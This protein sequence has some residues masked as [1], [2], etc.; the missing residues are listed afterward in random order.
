MKKNTTPGKK[1][2]LWSCW[3]LLLC[4]G[5]PIAG[6][7]QQPKL[8]IRGNLQTETGNAVPNATVLI[9]NKDSSFSRQ[10]KADEEGVFAVYGLKPGDYSINISSVGY[11]SARYRNIHYDGNKVL[12][13]TFNLTSTSNQLSEVVVVGYGTDSKRNLTSS[14]TSVTAEAFNKG[15]YSDPLQ[16][17]QGKVAGLT[18][19]RSGDPNV[20]A[21]IL[22][23]GP[24]TLRDGANA[25][26]VVI[27]GVPDADI[28]AVAPGDIATI[29]VLKDAAATAI[30]GN[31]GANGIL[32]ITTR[33]GKKG[34]P[35]IA[36]DGYVSIDKVSNRIEVMN[37]AQIQDFLAKNNQALSAADDGG[38]DT[39]WQKVIQ[40]N[41]AQSQSHN[42]SVSGGSNNTMYAASGNYFK[43]EGIMIGSKVERYTGRLV[44]E[45]Q[46]LNNNLKLGFNVINSVNDAT[47]SPAQGSAMSQA[48]KYLPTVTPYRADGTYFENRD[49]NGYYNPLALMNNYSGKEQSKNLIANV[50]ALVKLP[51]GFSYSLSASYKSSQSDSK[52]FRTGYYALIGQGNAG[53]EASRS[54][55]SNRSSIL[56]TYLN[57]DKTFGEHTIKALVGYSYQKDVSGDGFAASNANFPSDD[58]SYYWLG[59]GNTPASYAIDW[60]SNRYREKLLI[61]D[62]GRLNYSYADKYLLQASIRHDGS[63]VFGANQRWGIFP[64]VSAGWRIIEERFM[65]KQHL[66]DDLK[67]RVGYGITGNSNGID[68]L[69]PLQIYGSRGTEYFFYEGSWI[70]PIGVTQNANPDLKWE[71]TATLNAA[72]D[73][74]LLKRRI[75]GTLEVYSK[76]TSDLIWD[77]PVSTTRYPVNKI[78]ANAGKMRN[79][80]IELTL[81]VEAVHGKDFTWSSSLNLS[82]NYNKIVSLTNDIYILDSINTAGAGG[83][84]QSGGTIQL[85]KPGLPIGQFFLFK[86]AGK[87]DD[88]RTQFYDK[89]GKVQTDLT[90]LR[91]SVDY[92][93]LGNAQPKMQIGWSN[94]FSYKNFDLSIFLRSTLGNKIYNQTRA[95]LWRP[96]TVTWYNIPVS[97]KDE[98]VTDVYS[99]FSSDRFIESGSYVRLDNATLGY[100]FKNPLKSIQSARIYVTGNNL[101]VITGYS[102]I[103]PEVNLSGL[104]PGIDNSSYYPKFRS[105]MFGL[106]VTL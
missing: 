74:S 43:Q 37:S 101:F 19:T 20:S 44:I 32:M 93:Q 52:S 59:W 41:K 34:Q 7:A 29:D 36:Y 106:N 8:S 55:Y 31:R 72:I 71:K 33:K 66:F 21:S 53:G 88:G 65:R 35:R 45:Q 97:A 54:S 80:G 9:T 75:S 63:S 56:E 89:S 28:D 46:A 42:I 90:S 51:A 69:T 95:E 103:D 49:H 13:L 48:L 82:H 40:R 11:A 39:D 15:V 25:P 18:I 12:T 86:Y 10:V 24:S 87:S 102:G 58:L 83:A 60:G 3:C 30:Y 6:M 5:L 104:T 73:F 23:R 16:I 98:S 78:T 77:Y 96:S 68:A 4:A 67:L 99:N 105:F 84:G 62:Y 47:S 26:L 64:S 38:A 91:N 22:L 2:L 27:D 92:Y 14:I 57:Y 79:T 50:N 70:I 17:L 1:Y 76:T 85:L 94:S 100:T 61:S 81:N